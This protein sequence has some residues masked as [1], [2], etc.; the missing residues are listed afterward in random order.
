MVSYHL[1]FV[2]II[3]P[4]WSWRRLWE[5]I[6]MDGRTLV[7]VGEIGSPRCQ[8]RHTWSPLGR[9]CHALCYVLKYV[10]SMKSMTIGG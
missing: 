9:V 6:A 7:V 1:A 3:I 4:M 10:H 8:V 5:K 2:T